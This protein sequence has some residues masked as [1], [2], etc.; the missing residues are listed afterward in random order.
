[1]IWPPIS[2]MNGDH[3]PFSLWKRSWSSRIFGVGF[4][5]LDTSRPSP[6]L[7]TSWINQL[8]L[9]NKHSSLE[10][11]FKQQAA[12]PKFHHSLG[13]ISSFTLTS[14]PLASCA[15]S[16]GSTSETRYFNYSNTP[17]PGHPPPFCIV[18][19]GSSPSTLHDQL[20]YLVSV[21]H[22]Q[23]SKPFEALIESKVPWKAFL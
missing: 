6:R 1:M 17:S 21:F 2:A 13:V 16:S 22:S 8:F 7:L 20:K 15:T 4:S 5:T 12:E 18:Y 23:L 3:F 9:S 19:T 11:V 10:Y 14:D